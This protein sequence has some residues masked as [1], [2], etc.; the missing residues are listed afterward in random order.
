ML[1][2]SSSQMS[3]VRTGKYL[4]LYVIFCL[5]IFI[6]QSCAPSVVGTYTRIQRAA[7]QG[8]IDTVGRYATVAR[9]PK[10]QIYSIKYLRQF[11]N[12]R[13]AYGYLSEVIEKSYNPTVKNAAINSLDSFL[14]IPSAKNLLMEVLKKGPLT[15]RYSVIESIQKSGNIDNPTKISLISTSLGDRSP[16]VRIF[17]ARSLRLLGDYS[18]GPEVYDL[19]DED[20]VFVRR[21]AAQE[22]FHHMKEEY[23]PK[24]KNLTSDV[25]PKVR[26]H[27]KA[28]L[29]KLEDQNKSGSYGSGHTIPTNFTQKNQSTRGKITYY[30]LVIGNNRYTHLTPLRSAVYDA[31]EVG[32]IL[33]N[34]FGFTVFLLLN[35]TRD[36]MIEEFENLRATLTE[37]DSLLIYYA[38]HGSIDPVAERGYW[39]PVDAKMES[40]ARWISNADITDSLKAIPSKHV[41]V[42]ADSCY[43][44]MLTRD[45]VRSIH[46]SK[47]SKHY[48][49][50][51]QKVLARKS[52]TVLTSG[53]NEPVLDSGGGKHSVFAKSFLQALGELQKPFDGTALYS[54]V[55]KQIRLDAQQSPQYGDIRHT[56][57]EVGGD[58]VF[59]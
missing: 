42:V 1:K 47:K 29:A 23:G 44:G 56:G 51:L 27:A 7:E 13:T 38:G 52:R 53:A 55:R 40:R 4:S 50:H 21:E 22:I 5:C 2:K 10:I 12:N 24:V 39:L 20:Y 59:Y 16:A 33:E 6:I 36:R 31:Q 41:L 46:K 37:D 30:A 54:Y 57:H 18:A 9:E 58:F 35:S 34:K 45:S 8:D 14:D 43:S 11:P 49:S 19:L 32:R 17:A 25:D 15:T 3:M 48:D 28:A 26:K